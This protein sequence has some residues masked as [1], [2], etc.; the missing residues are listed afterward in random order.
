MSWTPPPQI[1]EKRANERES[2]PQRDIDAARGISTVVSYFF[3]TNIRCSFKR[4]HELF[5]ALCVGTDKCDVIK[6]WDDR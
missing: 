1:E 2:Q 5:V 6:I 3:V 4:S